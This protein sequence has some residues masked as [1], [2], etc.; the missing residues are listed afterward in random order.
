MQL[1]WAR[2]RDAQDSQDACLHVSGLEEPQEHGR[3]GQRNTALS[4]RWY[5][6]ATRAPRAPLR[7]Q[8]PVASAAAADMP[9]CIAVVW[10][11]LSPLSLS[12]SRLCSVP[13]RRCWGPRTSSVR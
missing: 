2:G 9:D 4:G 11:L 3:R 6:R 1:G 12:R 7:P 5:V 8:I 13:S 10:L